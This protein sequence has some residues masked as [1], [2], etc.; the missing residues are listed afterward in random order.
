VYENRYRYRWLSARRYKLDEIEINFSYLER[1]IGHVDDI[2][3]NSCSF[4]TTEQ[5]L[6]VLKAALSSLHLVECNPH[7]KKLK[8]VANSSKSK[9][10]SYSFCVRMMTYLSQ[11]CPEVIWVDINV[12]PAETVRLAMDS[13]PKL[14]TIRRISSLIISSDE[15][16]GME[17][18]YETSSYPNVEAI[19]LYCGITDR[20]W[21]PLI[22]A[23]PNLKSLD[24]DVASVRSNLSEILMSCSKLTCLHL[25]GFDNSLN[26]IIFDQAISAIA[27]YGLQLEELEM[28]ICVTW[29]IAVMRGSKTRDDMITILKRVRSFELNYDV[30]NIHNYEDDDD[31][32]DDND[33]ESSI[34]LLFNSPGVDLRSLKIPTYNEN[35]DKIALMLQGCRNI[36]KLNLKAR[37]GE[38]LNPVMMKISAICHQ[39]VDLTLSYAANFING[40]AMQ[41]LLQSCK[42][43]E[44]LEL[45][46]Y[47]GVEA[48]ESLALYGLNLQTIS[49]TSY[50]PCLQSKLSFTTTSPL[51]DA[52][53][54]QLRK[55]PVTSFDIEQ[56]DLDVK[57]L[58]TFLSC[59]GL[60]EELAMQLDSS[61]LPDD[62]DIDTTDGIPLYHARQV[63]IF[64]YFEWNGEPLDSVFAALMNS[65]R[66]LRE[67]RIGPNWDEKSACL[68][69]ESTLIRFAL[70]CS[71]RNAPLISLSYPE[72]VKLPNLKEL[73]PK[74]RLDSMLPTVIDPPSISILID[75]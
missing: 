25:S 65:C 33:S 13:F 64:S 30:V 27:E 23:C 75:S 60:I 11:R 26:S 7:V 2:S 35:A 9:K 8:L 54:K 68:V 6:G 46:S 18:D 51:N 16:F 31:D 59:F 12:V 69:S 70:A 57:S 56:C 71:Q 73:L 39:L 74:L 50:K 20:L 21:V 34:C 53:F 15:S 61:Q 1:V 17:F 37:G 45:V 47:L 5:S 22:N 24:C 49:L 66:S 72:Q 29:S 44:K 4:H 38:A 63:C 19:Q 3:F 36:E 42:Q 48:Y 32:D 67:L 41:A 52:K 58:A 14:T 40:G 28:D 43:L 10:V 55:H 62:Y